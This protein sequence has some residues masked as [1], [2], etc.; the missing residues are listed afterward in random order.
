MFISCLPTYQWKKNIE[1]CNCVGAGAQKVGKV[2]N[3]MHNFDLIFTIF[4]ECKRGKLYISK[5]VSHSTFKKIFQNYVYNS[6][7]IFL[8]RFYFA[9]KGTLRP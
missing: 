7:F 6:T 9:W 1:N 5:K 2:V 4:G 8:T 3:F